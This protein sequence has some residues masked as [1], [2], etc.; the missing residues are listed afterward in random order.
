M[1][2]CHSHFTSAR[3]C[4][5]VRGKRTLRERSRC[6]ERNMDWRRIL[7]HQNLP[8]VTDTYLE[9]P[10]RELLL[11]VDGTRPITSYGGD[12]QQLAFSYEDPLSRENLTVTANPNS[13]YLVLITDTMYQG[14]CPSLHFYF[15]PFPDTIT[16]SSLRNASEPGNSAAVSNFASDEAQ[17]T[18]LACRQKLQE[19]D[20]IVTLW[21]PGLTIR[22]E[23]EVMKGLFVGIRQKAGLSMELR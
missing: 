16:R 23:D 5:R 14:D 4:A 1:G 12:V 3:G 21:L 15:E 2:S 13:A 10:R 6:A 19:L 20:A 18:T 11:A 7:Y 22:E 17:V 8:K 9:K